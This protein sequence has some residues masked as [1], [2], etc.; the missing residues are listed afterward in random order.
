M[1]GSKHR[2][3]LKEEQKRDNLK[4]T[5]ELEVDESGLSEEEK[6]H[7]SFPWSFLI[8]AGSIIIVMAVVIILIFVFGGPIKGDT[9]TSSDIISELI[10]DS[11]LL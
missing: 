9:K 6:G 3:E 1:F 2:K 8:V 11:V 5:K 7:T 10:S 4:S